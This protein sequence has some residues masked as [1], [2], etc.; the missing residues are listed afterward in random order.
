MR[1]LMERAFEELQS[2]KVPIV[3]A[4][5]GYGK[6]AASPEIYRRAKGEGLASGLIHV[7][8]LR[9]LVTMIYTSFFK[10]RGGAYQMHGSIE[11][12]DKSPYFLREL[13]VTTLDSYLWNLFRIPVL[14]AHVVEAGMSR[15]HYYPIYTSIL[16]SVNVLDEAHLMIGGDRSTIVE[17][18]QAT[19]RTLAKLEAQMIIETAT[20]PSRIL[21]E[22]AKDVS[23]YGGRETIVLALG[24][25]REGYIDLGLA[26]EGVNVEYVEDE[27]WLGRNNELSWNTSLAGGWESVVDDMIRDSDEG[28]VLGVSN[29]VTGAIRLY[30]ELARRAREK[31]N[32]VLIHGRLA[33]EDRLKAERR[34]RELS[35]GIVVSTP[36]IE[37]GVDVNSIAV[38]TEA[39]PIENL[40]Q[41]VGRACRR[42]ESLKRC[43]DEGG[44]VVVLRENGNSHYERREVE[45][46]LT[47]IGRRSE[48]GIDWRVPC[49]EKGYTKLINEAQS[50][51]GLYPNIGRQALTALF[52]AY[53]NN[54]GKPDALLDVLKTMGSCGI[55]RSVLMVP[56]MTPRGT[57]TADLYWTLAKAE[58]V[59]E[60]EEGAPRIIVIDRFQERSSREEVASGP[61]KSLWERWKAGRGRSCSMLALNL[62]NDVSRILASIQRDRGAYTW[63]FKARD[64]AYQEGV[65]LTGGGI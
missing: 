30:N 10:K 15:G 22:I 34:M 58:E 65:G 18:I 5:T 53:L 7:A 1:P 40:V 21:K 56:I 38:Y 37:A 47:L 32:L 11:F 51:H 63:F 8:P 17:S 24:C 59:L 41:R 42:G 50:T 33:E 20:M 13:V 12:G 9:S 39:A 27:D 46:A 2:G 4:P 25:G 3:I 55:Y 52:D 54:D 44:K 35:R 61:A 57:V 31:E 28:L 29:T 45:T 14:E 36:V 48:E 26:G 60:F 64:E 43:I 23:R 19:V 16:T 62:K 6:T 49:G